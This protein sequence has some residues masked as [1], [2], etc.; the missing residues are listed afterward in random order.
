MNKKLIKIFKKLQEKADEANNIK[1]FNEIKLIN[2]ILQIMD[3]EI[4]L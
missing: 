4:L 3:D 2:T 1:D